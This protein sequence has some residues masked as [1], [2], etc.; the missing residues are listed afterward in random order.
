MPRIECFGGQHFALLTWKDEDILVAGR[1]NAMKHYPPRSV[2]GLELW[3]AFEY[4]FG[5]GQTYVFQ[6]PI[7]PLR[8]YRKTNYSL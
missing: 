4:F 3:G 8:L 7:K 6:L 2:Q 5:L 1:R